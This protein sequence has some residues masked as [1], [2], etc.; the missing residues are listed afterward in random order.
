LFG[1]ASNFVVSRGTSKTCF[2]SNRSQVLLQ[3]FPLVGSWLAR[4]ICSIKYEFMFF[5]DL[6]RPTIHAPDPTWN[7][8]AEPVSDSEV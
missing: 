4:A 5:A 1:A 8:G 3:T 7:E 2:I 6:A